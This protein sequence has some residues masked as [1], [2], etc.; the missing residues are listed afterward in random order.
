MMSKEHVLFHQPVQGFHPG[1][2]MHCM[3]TRKALT[4][5]DFGFFMGEMWVSV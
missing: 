3:T 4:S 2:V 1:F 5:L